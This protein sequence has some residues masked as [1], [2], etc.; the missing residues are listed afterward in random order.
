MRWSDTYFNGTLKSIMGLPEK[1][2]KV[3]GVSRPI[4]IGVSR[5]I[6]IGIKTTKLMKIAKRCAAH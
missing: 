4:E 6:R 5:P 3:G 1:G 2:A